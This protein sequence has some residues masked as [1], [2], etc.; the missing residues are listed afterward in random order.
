MQHI[1][2]NREIK[3]HLMLRS[4][5]IEQSSFI[6]LEP[7]VAIFVTMWKSICKLLGYVSVYLDQ[8][9]GRAA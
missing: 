7:F 8:R 4:G 9:L 5:K 6:S 1:P 3:F 2:I